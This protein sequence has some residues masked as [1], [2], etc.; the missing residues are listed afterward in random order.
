VE[1]PVPAPTA[2]EFQAS[3]TAPPHAHPGAGGD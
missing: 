1:K 3:S 2:P